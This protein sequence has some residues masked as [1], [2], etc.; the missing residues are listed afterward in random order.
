MVSI[1]ELYVEHPLKS[2]F[3]LTQAGTHCKWIND[4]QHFLL[5]HFET[6]HNS[7][8][9]IYYSALPFTPSSSW[10]HE[11][12]SA[13]FS[14]EVRV[15]KGL[16]DKWGTCSHTASLCDTPRTL[17]CWK[18]VVAVSMVSGNIIILSAVTGTQVAIFSGQTGWVRSL[19]FSLDGTLLVSRGDDMPIKIWDMQTGGVI[20]SFHGSHTK[21]VCS[22]SISPDCTVVASGSSDQRIR[23]WNIQTRECY[24]TIETPVPVYHIS[25]SPRNSQ[26]LIASG[27]NIFGCK[28]HQWNT[29]GHQIGPTYDGDG[30][31]FSPDGTHFASYSKTAVIIQNSSSGMIVA[32][33]QVTDNIHH[34]CFSPNG[35]LVAAAAG[36]TAYVWNITNLDPHLIETFVGHTSKITSLTFSSYLISTSV[37]QS[38]KFWPIDALLTDPVISDQ[39]PTPSTS[40]PIISTGLQARDGI[41]LSID[42]AGVVKIWN[43]FTGH[44]NGS[45]Q[46]PAKG[47]LLGDAQL[48]DSGLVIV[49]FKTLGLFGERKVYIWNSKKGGCP[50][51]VDVS[52]YPYYEPDSLIISGDRFFLG[53][54]H[55]SRQLSVEV[56]SLQTRKAVAG[57]TTFVTETSLD[58]LYMDGSRVCVRLKDL[59][60]VGWDGTLYIPLERPHL[61]FINS[62]GQWNAGPARVKNTTSGGEVFH[63]SGRYAKPVHTRWDG[64]YLVAGYCS[65]EVLILDFERHI[66]PQ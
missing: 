8:S 55:P 43:I 62:P 12:Y 39:T 58:P 35:S 18:D 17:A 25:F 50:Q 65:G 24:S 29:N 37:D 38:V 14:Q 13:E 23:L 4:S 41:A 60:R 5:E 33:L 54:S 49:W 32:K 30:G 22:V 64:Q 9:H 52:L 31:T 57:P 19:A 36:S 59:S 2:T 21:F 10:L 3:M 63:L 45:F 6:I 44:C 51:P 47:L 26:H 11:Y 42:L 28:V 15:V 1:G 7:P 61:D 53:H 40:A 48:V 46:T 16:P 66:L 56:L 20:T 34:C 27:S